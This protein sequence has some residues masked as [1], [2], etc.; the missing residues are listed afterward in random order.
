MSTP[1]FRFMVSRDFRIVPVASALIWTVGT[2]ALGEETPNV[3]TF[4][5]EEL[6]QVAAPIWHP[7]D[8]SF[9]PLH[10]PGMPPTAPTSLVPDA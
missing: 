5:P 2:P 3:P 7:L 6:E 8:T 1:R 4:S 10:D 9:H